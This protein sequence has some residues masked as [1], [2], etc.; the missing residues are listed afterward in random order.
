VV[1]I[2][3]LGGRFPQ[4]ANAESAKIRAKQTEQVSLHAGQTPD[5]PGGIFFAPQHGV[6][7]IADL[8]RRTH[9]RKQLG[10]QEI[11]GRSPFESAPP[12]DNGKEHTLFLILQACG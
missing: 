3:I 6:G 5:V 8:E 11:L 12:I 4:T 9:K 7:A 2:K 1:E 10:S